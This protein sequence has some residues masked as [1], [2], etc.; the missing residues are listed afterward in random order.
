MARLSQLVPTKITEPLLQKQ[1]N[2][3]SPNETMN[4]A[5]Q[6]VSLISVIPQYELICVALMTGNVIPDGALI[7]AL[8]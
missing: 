3:S 7:P 2:K 6:F 5:T 8:V 1:R 4:Q